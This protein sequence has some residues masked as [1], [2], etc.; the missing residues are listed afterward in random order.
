MIKNLSDGITEKKH[1]CGLHNQIN[2]LKARLDWSNHRT[3]TQWIYIRTTWLTWAMMGIRTPRFPALFDA[4]KAP[5]TSGLV[6]FTASARRSA[7]RF[8]SRPSWTKSSNKRTSKASSRDSTSNPSE[9]SACS[10]ILVWE[11][12]DDVNMAERTYPSLFYEMFVLSKL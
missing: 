10:S 7:V 2:I 5:F 4:F 6:G 1:H 11:D 12:D 9:S 8:P 3:F